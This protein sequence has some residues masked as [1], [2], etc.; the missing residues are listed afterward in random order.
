MRSLRVLS[1]AVVLCA[2][3]LGQAPPDYARESYIIEQLTRRADFQNDG[4]GTIVNSAR[5]QLK[6]EAGVRAFG[7]LVFGYNS[8]N[9]RLEIAY[10]RVRKPDGQ[11][12]TAGPDAVQ[13][14]TS[15]L[16]RVAPVYTDYRQKHVTV[17][18][19]RP[20]DTLE[21]SVSTVIAT[22]VAP[23]QFWL[24]HSF[25][26]SAIVL[27]E[28]LVV[29]VPRARSIKLKTAPGVVPAVVS[30]EDGRRI[31]RWTAA[32]KLRDDEEQ[33]PRKKKK[34]DEPADVQLT[35]FASWEE[36]GAWY[37]RLQR[38]RR[39]ATPEIRAK[40]EELTHDRAS[41][42]DKL[43]AIYDFVAQRVRYVSL[44]FGVG[45][46]QP[47]TAT[48]V[49]ANRYGDCKDK[50]TLLAALAETAG[51]QPAAVLIPSS[52][53]LDPEVPSPAQFDHVLSLVAIGKDNVWL[54]TTT[55][56]APFRLLAA[57][58]RQ[59]QA[60]VVP[61]EGP[62]RL[63]ETPA[64]PPFP[65]RRSFDAAGEISAVGKLTLHMRQSFRGDSELAAR[66]A[67]RRVPE[68]EWKNMMQRVSSADIDGAEVADLKVGDPAATRD[69]YV[70]EFQLARAGYLDVSNKDAAVAV[71]LPRV[72]L[73]AADEDT[74]DPID[75]GPPGEWSEHLKLAL[76]EN[77]QARLPVPLTVTRDYGDYRSG[78]RLEGRTL[79]VDRTLVLR[80]AEL[81]AARVGDYLAFRRAVL[82]D[83][84]QKLSLETTSAGGGPAAS[85]SAKEL[86]EAGAA[87]LNNRNYKAAVDLLQRAVEL[88]PRHSSAWG[89]L[90]N[91]YY[92]QRRLD[93]AIAA[94]RSQIEVNPYDPHAYNDLGL[95]LWLSEK[96]D[97]ARA[98]FQ[99]QI[100]ISP[101]DRD[102][103]HS[104]GVFLLERHLYAEAVPELEKA[105]SLNSGNAQLQAELGRAYLNV[106]QD[107]KAMTAFARAAE[108]GPNPLVW[109]SIAYGMASSKAHWDRAQQYA[110]SAVASVSAVTRNWSLDTLRPQDLAVVDMLTSTWDTLGWIL[111]QRGQVDKAMPFLQAAWTVSQHGEVG[112]HLAQIYEKRGQKEKAIQTYAQALAAIRPQPE[113]RARLAA[114]VGD[115][116]VDA[117]VQ[118][119]R[120]ELVALRTR[121]LGR[122]A[123]AGRAEFLILVTPGK[124]HDVKFISGDEK[125]R[126]A[127]S[128]LRAADYGFVFPDSSGSRILRRGTLSC[129]A[130]GECTLLLEI[131]ENVTAMN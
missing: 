53:K 74:E 17:P 115:G 87:A 83:A 114:L 97:D 39:E 24:A 68:T 108:L 55:E 27:D 54:D 90:G 111:Y 41:E 4:S 19:L 105:A 12:I 113:T 34:R 20:G 118:A 2:T 81:P 6:S 63:A 119:A 42:L 50:H 11:V 40:A 127:V 130:A 37:A 110:E 99:K 28:Q 117:L 84:A 26:Q 15:G 31:Y 116:K 5:V 56:V 3:A 103:H 77:Y 104:L 14:I 124:S 35:T 62:A 22:P 67:F 79:I 51:L 9:E 98:A 30:D 7:Q 64:D 106:G 1:L 10:V 101:L 85:M 52:R 80:Q 88:E 18:G 16:T 93:E 73:P 94:Y 60:L 100:E 122:I 48:E 47:H 57:Q 82:S 8:G 58:L 38:D 70:L 123:G 45:Q 92:A 76:P 33:A 46:Y 75:L 29:S 36:V 65:A 121:P 120:A 23:G 96:Y 125:L 89:T 13:D 109:N 69:P 25:N 107:E 61:V 32:H 129:T 72:T 44:S 78:Y 86:V 21:Y 71:P 95:A 102:A 66:M 131:P 59:K 91:A 49:L 126:S 43:E 112:D 128:V